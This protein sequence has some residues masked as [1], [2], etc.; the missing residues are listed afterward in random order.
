MLLNWAEIEA[1]KLKNKDKVNELMEIYISENGAQSVSW[2][3]Y[4]KFIRFFGDNK[5]VRTLCKRGL[6]YCDDFE[7]LGIAWLEWEKKFGTI[8]TITECEAKIKKKS[9]RIQ[10]QMQGQMLQEMAVAEERRR[11][12]ERAG[13]GDAKRKKFEEEE[14]RAPPLSKRNTLYVKNIP[15]DT[16]EDEL[17]DVFK[18]VGKV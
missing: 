10:E 15:L 7:T 5:M 13:P 2:L 11:K 17:E 6:E 12:F 4:I 9:A 16:F 18:A 14:K 3:N 1:Y 8:Q